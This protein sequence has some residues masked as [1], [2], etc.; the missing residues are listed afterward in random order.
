MTCA[1]GRTGGRNFVDGMGSVIVVRRRR[2]VEV[3][4]SE[5]PS[6]SAIPSSGTPSRR[7]AFRSSSPSS[8]ADPGRSAGSRA[9]ACSMQP[10]TSAGNPADVR[11]G[12]P[13]LA[14]RRKC[15]TT[16]SPLRLSNA[17]W[18]VSAQNRV[19]PSP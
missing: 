4:G 10:D 11:S 15:A 14:T 16:C 6:G 9:I 7:C 1:R 18:P 8:A 5:D 17:A 3:A 2:G 12:T 19:A 13:S